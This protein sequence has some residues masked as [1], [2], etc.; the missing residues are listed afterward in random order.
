MLQGSPTF[1]RFTHQNFSSYD[2]GKPRRPLPGKVKT[3]FFGSVSMP[4]VLQVSMSLRCDSSR[5][6][7]KGIARQ[8]AESTLTFDGLSAVIPI[9]LLTTEERGVHHFEV[10]LDG[11]LLTKVP[12]EIEMTEVVQ[13]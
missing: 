5:H 3:C 8:M 7:G 10:G 6:P 11:R 2:A 4:T 9:H 1:L 12:F 13:A